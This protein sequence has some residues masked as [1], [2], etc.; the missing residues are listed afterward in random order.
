MQGFWG[1][2]PAIL[3]IMMLAAAVF[4][5]MTLQRESPAFARWE[6]EEASAVS[7]AP[8]EEASGPSEQALAPL[9]VPLTEN[10]DEM[11]AVWVPYL[12]LDMRGGDGSAASFQEKFDEIVRTSKERGMNTLIVQVRP[13]GDALYESDYFPWSH[14]LTGRQGIHPGYDPLAYM[15]EAA[16][17]E[18]LEI[19]AWLNPLRIQLETNPPELAQ[20]NPY[21]EWKRDPA[22]SGW[23]VDYGN[24]K[25]YNP[26]YPEVRRLIAG[27][28]RE[29]VE[30]YDVD[31]I[32]FDDYFYPTEKEEF[33]KAAYDAY[34][35]EQGDN[36]APLADW[37]QENINLLIREVY[38]AVKEADPDVVFGISPQANLQNDLRMGADVETWCSQEGYLDYI[39]P[40]LYVN[41]D[42]PTLPFETAAD[43]WCSLQRLDSVK[44]YFGLALYKANSDADDGTWKSSQDILARQILSGRELG[45]DGFFFYSWEYLSADQ[46]AQEVANVMSVL[47]G[48]SA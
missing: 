40:Q 13:F 39:C 7:G 26:A 5:T 14:L 22:K 31:G 37:R 1:R 19:H 17:R 4:L 6:A 36:A 10:V 20:S 28:A 38:A 2:H 24:G 25:Y 21:Q 9:T 42:H 12:S 46:T 23:T 18:G 8:A 16:H 43:Q 15:V 27:G 3:S 30:K 32:H 47:Q 41:S 11:R 48:E 44:L 29:I 35:A 45:A 34:K 33:D